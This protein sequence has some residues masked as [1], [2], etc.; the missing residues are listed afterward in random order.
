MRHAAL[1]L[2]PGMNYSD[3][4]PESQIRWFTQ[5]PG[6]WGSVEKAGT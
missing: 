2:N 5:E 1:L 4:D 3:K 6:G